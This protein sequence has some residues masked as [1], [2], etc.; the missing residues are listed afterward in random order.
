MV[1]VRFKQGMMN[2][3]NTISKNYIYW[4]WNFCI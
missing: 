1:I 4:I 2:Q 3:N